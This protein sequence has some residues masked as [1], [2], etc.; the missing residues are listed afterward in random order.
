MKILQELRQ[1]IDR[2][3]D[4]CKKELK[5]MRSSQEK[6]ENSFAKMKA[7]LKVMYSRM[8][9]GEER[10]SDLEERIIEITQ[11]EQQTE[12]QMKQKRKQYKR[13]MGL[14]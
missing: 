5:T 11:P 1:A 12:S 14:A 8:N 9:N 6:L 2:N 3:A 13:P 10:K 7:E 4:Y